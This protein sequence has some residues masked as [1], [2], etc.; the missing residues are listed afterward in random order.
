MTVCKRMKTPA[1]LGR[2]FDASSSRGSVQLS[3][4]L[5]A[6]YLE[7]FFGKLGSQKFALMHELECQAPQCKNKLCFAE[8]QDRDVKNPD[9]IHQFVRE[10]KH[11]ELW[12]R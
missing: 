7:L 10:Y 5:A 2:R 1:M 6:R 12:M 8:V 9:E 4:E 11:W 3:R